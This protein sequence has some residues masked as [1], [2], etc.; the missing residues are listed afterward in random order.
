MMIKEGTRVEIKSPGHWAHKEWGIVKGLIG[1]E[2]HVAPW[3]GDNETI[4]L[5]R[6]ELIVKR[7]T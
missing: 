6:D 3:G 1:D 4:I 2:Y 5:Y 7:K